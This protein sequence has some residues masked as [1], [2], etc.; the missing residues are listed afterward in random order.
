MAEAKTAP[1]DYLARRM[2]HVRRRYADV[3]ACAIILDEIFVSGGS[4]LCRI[5][6]IRMK[7]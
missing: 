3:D 1:I 2:L 6:V 4:Y 7:A 5:L